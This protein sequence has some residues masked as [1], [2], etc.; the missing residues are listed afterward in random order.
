MVLISASKFGIPGAW[1][2]DALS[3]VGLSKRKAPGSALSVTV[4]ELAELTGEWLDG[5]N[6]QA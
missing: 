1:G 3:V 5:C 2:E 6:I 4:V